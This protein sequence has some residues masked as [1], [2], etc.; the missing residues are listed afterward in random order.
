MADFMPRFREIQETE[1]LLR[2]KP[3]LLLSFGLLKM[4]EVNPSCDHSN[5]RVHEFAAFL[6]LRYRPRFLAMLFQ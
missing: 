5:S 2:Q 4:D 1:T 3:A 6:M